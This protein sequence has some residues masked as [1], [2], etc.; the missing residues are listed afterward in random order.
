MISY[1]AH[2]LENPTYLKQ[3]HTSYSSL[4]KEFKGIFDDLT[5]HLKAQ[6]SEIDGLKSKMSASARST[7]QTDELVSARMEAALREERDIAA[8]KRQALLSQITN[9]VN[10]SAEQQERRSVMKVQELQHQL[11]SSRS[12]LASADEEFNSG[13]GHWSSREVAFTN[14]VLESRDSIKLKLKEDWKAI[15]ERNDSIHS[16]TKSVHEETVRIVDAQMITV[17]KQMQALDD[18]VARARSHNERHHDQHTASLGRL[19]SVVNDSHSSV[20]KHFMSTYDRIREAGNEL[21]NRSDELGM[22]IPSFSGAL[23]ANLADLRANIINSAPVEYVPTGLTPQRKEYEY[24]KTLPRTDAHENLLGR[25]PRNAYSPS[26]SP[27]KPKVYADA[28]SAEMPP[29]LSSSTK[30]AGLREIS[31][32]VGAALHRNNSDSAVLNLQS[33]VKHVGDKVSGGPPPLKRQATE[34]KL[35][36]KLGG[37]R[38]G[39]VKLEGNENLGASVGSGGRRLRSSPGD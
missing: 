26:K 2:V 21:S 29:A 25:K 22:N 27:S 18:F 11:L 9:L 19:A 31:L 37:G 4:G 20:G 14:S 8:Q 15:N 39:L 24:T 13:V 36:T 34:S 7:I 28:P 35:P 5:R 30:D 17:A 38:G 10:K 16:T 23:E 1:S 6:R 33:A 3:L 32:N 12:G